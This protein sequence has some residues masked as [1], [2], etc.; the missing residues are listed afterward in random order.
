MEPIKV[1]ISVV[2]K[3]HSGK[4]DGTLFEFL[5][6]EASLLTVSPRPLVILC[7]LGLKGAE[8]AGDNLGAG[9]QTTTMFTEAVSGSII[10]IFCV[11]LSIL[12]LT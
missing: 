12:A 6:S 2:D 7:Q 4:S 5:V 11:L 8:D 10:F 3:A 1:C 9:Q